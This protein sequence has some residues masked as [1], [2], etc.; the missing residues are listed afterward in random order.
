LE[1]S[2]S[3]TQQAETFFEAKQSRRY[4]GFDEREERETELPFDPR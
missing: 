3:R 2:V 1:E 4:D